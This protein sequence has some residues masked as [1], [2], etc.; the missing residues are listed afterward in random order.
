M[1]PVL[2]DIYKNINI[3]DFENSKD[4]EEG[5]YTEKKIM[6]ILVKDI[7]KNKIKYYKMKFGTRF[8]YISS[9]SVSKIIKYDRVYFDNFDNI[10][11]F[12]NHKN[13][14]LYW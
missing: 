12:W 3:K 2:M 7:G 14:K 9:D 4:I 11:A 13:G 8:I 5:E 1:I 6:T 10:I